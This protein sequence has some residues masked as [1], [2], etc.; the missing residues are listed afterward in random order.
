MAHHHRGLDLNALDTSQLAGSNA[1][2]NSTHIH[3]PQ[4]QLFGRGRW[5]LAR[6]HRPL[7]L[8]I[9]AW[10]DRQHHRV[11]ITRQMARPAL[12]VGRAIPEPMGDHHQPAVGIGLGLQ[13]HQHEWR[14]PMAHRQTQFT[15][16]NSAGARLSEA[17][18]GAH[19]HTRF[20]QLVGDHSLLGIALDPLHHL[21]QINPHGL[22]G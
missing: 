13:H 19:R 16:T 12:K 20:E 2:E 8:L 1:I 11:A 5:G 6:Q 4:P 17:G 21:G 3:G 10:M 9:T 14:R 18:I 15:T 7:L 22:A